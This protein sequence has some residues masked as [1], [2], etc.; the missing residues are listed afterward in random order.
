MLCNINYTANPF[1]KIFC[2]DCPYAADLC[3]NNIIQ[4][5]VELMCKKPLFSIR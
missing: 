4:Y 5:P 2:P 1:L 3:A